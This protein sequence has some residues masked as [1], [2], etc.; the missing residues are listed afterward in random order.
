MDKQNVRN[1]RRQYM[2]YDRLKKPTNHELFISI[3]F[4]LLEHN[5]IKEAKKL[6]EENNYSCKYTIA[7][8]Y[9]ATLEIEVNKI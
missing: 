3:V 1:R 8:N 6:L 9:L 7:T 4:A 2:R 5:Q